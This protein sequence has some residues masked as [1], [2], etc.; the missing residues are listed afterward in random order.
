[1]QRMVLR[2][3]CSIFSTDAACGV[4]RVPDCRLR[5]RSAVPPGDARL[6]CR[7]PGNVTAACTS[8]SNTRNRTPGTICTENAVS[9]IRL[10]PPL[11]RIVET[12]CLGLCAL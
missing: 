5:K 3:P 10:Q 7:A 9:C 4:L 8:K 6:D 1:M 2:V 12:A 11:K